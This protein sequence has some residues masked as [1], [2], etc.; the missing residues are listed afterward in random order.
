MKLSVL[1]TKTEGHGASQSAHM[2][3]TIGGFPTEFDLP[4]YATDGSVRFRAGDSYD[5]DISVTVSDA[6]ARLDAVAAEKK[7]EADAKA[8]EAAQ[9][10]Q[11]LAEAEEAKE[12]QA[13]EDALIQIEVRRQRAAVKAAAIVAAESAPKP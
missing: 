11:K 7:A 1:C 10:T 9:A 3:G 13:H 4:V 6:N 12:A 5:A 8:L 2:K